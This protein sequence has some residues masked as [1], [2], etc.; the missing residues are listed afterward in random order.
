MR[1]DVDMTV[2]E[3]LLSQIEVATGEI[4]RRDAA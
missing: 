3:R 2:A 4:A 1:W